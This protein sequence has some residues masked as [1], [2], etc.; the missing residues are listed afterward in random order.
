MCSH[1]SLTGGLIRPSVTLMSLVR[2][3]TLLGWTSCVI[4]VSDRKFCTMLLFG[5]RSQCVQPSSHSCLTAT[6][7]GQKKAAWQK[8]KKKARTRRE[9]IL[10]NNSL[11]TKKLQ[12]AAPRTKK[13]EISVNASLYLKSRVNTWITRY[14]NELISGGATEEFFSFLISLLSDFRAMYSLL[15]RIYRKFP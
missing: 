14:T 9:R 11:E 7:A 2:I 12:S 4:S 1:L 6:S 15:N 8:I 5:C 10:E 3:V 13:L